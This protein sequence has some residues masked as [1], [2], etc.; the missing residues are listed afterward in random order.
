L[1]SSEVRSTVLK[2][3][4]TDHR[5]CAT[6]Q[7]P[8]TFVG[9]DF[10]TADHGADSAC[11]VGLVR[12]EGD[13]IIN[14]EHYLIRPI[15]N[16]FFF[17]PIHG[18]TWEHVR[19]KPT[20][21]ELWPSI[22]NMLIGAEFIASHNVGFDRRVLESCCQAAKISMPE[23]R[24]VCTMKLSRRLWNIRPTSLSNV[25]RYLG[26][27]LDPHEVLSDAEACVGIVLAAYR[28]GAAI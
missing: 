20:F 17:T 14:R 19:E 8:L 21:E 26:L 18:I 25:C 2:R 24:F 3:G 9:L 23:V 7:T 1:S 10:E 11:A 16:S 28:A 4:S 12:V 5:G 6:N 22:Q 13:R 27:R 15:R